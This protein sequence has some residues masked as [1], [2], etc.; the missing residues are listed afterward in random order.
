MKKPG[1]KKTR[2]K[3]AD[4]RCS[5][6]GHTDVRPDDGRHDALTCLEHV[7]E[8]R[9][10]LMAERAPRKLKAEWWELWWEK[11]GQKPQ[12]VPMYGEPIPPWI[13]DG[14]YPS[15]ELALDE[16]KKRDNRFDRLVHVR[17]YRKA[18]S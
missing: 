6:C 16:K 4:I 12:F 8:Q 10:A 11:P 9:E 15:R 18:K 7:L 3:K 2:P 1:L 13:P 5:D 17:R 14:C